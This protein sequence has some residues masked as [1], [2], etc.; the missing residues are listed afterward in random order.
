MKGG[1]G[2]YTYH[3]VHALREKKNI[4][5]HV[6]AGGSQSKTRATSTTVTSKSSPL[7]V[8]NT[9]NSDTTSNYDDTDN[10]DIDN[11][12]KYV[13]HCDIIKKGDWN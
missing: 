11:N 8:N 3:L 10:H 6:A 7:I 2:R 1:V 9:S 4:E 12:N 5:I 13:V